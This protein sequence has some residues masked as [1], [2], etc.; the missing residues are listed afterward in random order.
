MIR[1]YRRNLSRR[2]GYGSCKYIPTCSEYGMIAIEKH[3]AFFGPDT[4]GLEDTQV[5]PFL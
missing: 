2:V 3:G 5:Q 4:Y 1:F